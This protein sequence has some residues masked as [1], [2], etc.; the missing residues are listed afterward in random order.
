MSDAQL[1]RHCAPTLAGI[2]PANLFNS[3]ETNLQK[4]KRIL[5]QWNHTLNA[6]GVWVIAFRTP[7]GG[8]LLYVFRPKQLKRTLEEPAASRLLERFGY[9]E[10]GLGRQIRHLGRR[11]ESSASFPHEIGLFLGYPAADVIGFIANGG[12]KCKCAGCWKVYGDERAAAQRFQRYRQCT[13][14]CC[15]RFSQ[16]NDIA[17]ITV[18]D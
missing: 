16:E 11:L 13:E 2:K 9:P 1:V 10:S 18:R 7:C 8:K 14:Q 17:G 5:R 4:E 3:D 6:K 12:K 15:R